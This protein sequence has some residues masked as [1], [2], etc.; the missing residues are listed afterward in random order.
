MG[1][2][3]LAA[4]ILKQSWGQSQTHHSEMEPMPVTPSD[5]PSGSGGQ[6]ANQMDEYKYNTLRYSSKCER[7]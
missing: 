3:K 2:E 7:I 1:Y 5:Q 6:Y 4:E